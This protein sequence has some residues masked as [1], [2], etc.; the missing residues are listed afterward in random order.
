MADKKEAKKYSGSDVVLTA[1]PDKG[2][3]FKVT[4]DSFSAA[5]LKDCKVEGEDYYVAKAKKAGAK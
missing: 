1:T 4:A 2:K 5:N 3:L